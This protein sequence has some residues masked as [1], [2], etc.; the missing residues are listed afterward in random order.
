MVF[1]SVLF[2]KQSPQQ[3]ADELPRLRLAAALPLQRAVALTPRL[4]VPGGLEHAWAR[5][6]SADF[7]HCFAEVGGRVF[8]VFQEALGTRGQV[9]ESVSARACWFTEAMG[10]WFQGPGG[11]SIADGWLVSEDLLEGDGFLENL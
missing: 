9:A 1:L 11:R 3:S 8:L 10:S 5:V 6:L 7:G 2:T 4:G